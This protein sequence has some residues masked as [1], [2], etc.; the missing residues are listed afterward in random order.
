MEERGLNGGEGGALAPVD[1]AASEAAAL[2]ALDGAVVE[3]V[4]IGGDLARLAPAQRVAYYRAVC[5]SL[6][7]NCLTQPFEYIRL[8]D[9]LRLYA[10]REATDQLRRLHRVS[11]EIVGREQQGDLY[12]V[13]ARATMPDGRTDESTGAACLT[14]LSGANLANA[15]MKAECVPLDSEILTRDGFRRYDQ[16]T[17]GEDVLAYDVLSDRSVW[18]PLDAVTVYDSAPLIRLFSDHRQFEVLCTPDHSWAIRTAPYEPSKRGDG[19]R[20]PRGPYANRQPER[21]LVQ[22]THIKTNHRLILAAPEIGTGESRQI[23]GAF[24]KTEPAGHGP[25]W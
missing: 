3:Q 8:Q 21:R 24:L 13:T 5:Q 18:T 10:K 16:L 20:G 12:V 23:V 22:T 15:L 17:I 2:A 14:G 9:R 6:G 11:V 4:V 19:S 1:P 25:V 7:L